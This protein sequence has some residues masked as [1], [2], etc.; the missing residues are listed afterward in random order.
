MSTNVTPN[1]DS[2]A[3]F[4]DSLTDSDEFFRA[5]SA[6]A[7][8]GIPLSALGYAQQFSNGPVYSDLVPG[9]LGVTGGD[10]LNY[11]VGGAQ[12]LTDRTIGEVLPAAIIRPDATAEDLAWRMDMDGQVARFLTDTAGQDLSGTAA[13][14]L[15]GYND[16]NDFLPTSPE[17]ALTEALAYGVSM[18][19]ST[20]QDA[21][22]LAAGGV[23]T[24]I[25]NTLQGGT[26]FPVTQ[27]DPVE[28]AALGGAAAAAYNQALD[29]GVATLEALGATVVVVDF[30]AIFTEI[31]QNFSS[32]GFQTLDDV[33]ILP[34][35]NGDGVD[36]VNPVVAGIPLDQIA[37]FDSVHPTAAMHGIMAG[38]QAAALTS[39]VHIGSDARDF[40]PG[41]VA[42]DLA[43]GNG[44][45]DHLR[46]GDG[47][48]IGLGGLGNDVIK[49]GDGDDL[50]VGGAGDDRMRGDA[51]NDILADG[52]GNDRTSGGLGAD[53]IIDGEGSD[54]HHGGAGDDTFVFTDAALRGETDNGFNLL[55]GNRGNDTVIVRVEDAADVST[56]EFG[57]IKIFDGLG[58][59]TIGV[60]NVEVV[61][62]TDLTG[63]A[64][65]DDQMATADLWNFI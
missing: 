3:Y 65:Y 22:A 40:L 43:L 63:E 19:S 9:L 61:E 12:V 6:V 38:F 7:F 8:F 52:D 35:S 1:F 53:L 56:I 18:A 27:N 28:L 55:L 51:G 39:D 57:S 33:V 29:A 25:L 16:F 13:S 58:M 26:V 20:I 15:I 44:G 47:H 14:I 2:I 4:G 24:I 64:F 11:A 45:R 42:N 41:T 37:F 48:D 21:A 34:D 32:Y 5:S 30:A 23:G 50:A 31:E 59:I 54:R 46:L 17:T 60:E 49:G 36:E 10:A 62:G